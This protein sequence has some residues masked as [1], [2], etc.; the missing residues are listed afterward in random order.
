MRSQLEVEEG[1]PRNLVGL[2]DKP[3]VVV[4]DDHPALRNC[5]IDLLQDELKAINIIGCEDGWQAVIVS[6]QLRPD[7][8]VM[9]VDLPGID[10]IEATRLITRAMPDIRVIGFSMHSDEEMEGKMRAAGAV[11]YVPKDVPIERLL[12]A[13]QMQLFNQTVRGTE[14]VGPRRESV[15]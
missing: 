3:C 2:E 12:A 15:S 5:L 9:D 6:M 10:G 8:V 14:V 11:D 1:L 7:V 4:V 13:I